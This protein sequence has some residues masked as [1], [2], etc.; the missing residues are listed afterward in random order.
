TAGGAVVRLRRVRGGCPRDRGGRARRD[1][2]P[3]GPGV[4]VVWIPQVLRAQTGG[5]KQLELPGGTVGE[6]V[7]EL[8]AKYPALRGQLL[9]RAGELNRVVNLYVNGAHG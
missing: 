5:N 9:S 1:L 7:G 8:S 4:S 3:R 6:V 2:R